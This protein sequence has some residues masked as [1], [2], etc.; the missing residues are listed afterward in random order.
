AAGPL[1]VAVLGRPL[2]LVPTLVVGDLV[3]AD[4]VLGAGH[5]SERE[6]PRGGALGGA[7]GGATE[8]AHGR[9]EGAAGPAGPGS[10]PTAGRR[11]GESLAR[12]L[13][14]ACALS[15]SGRVLAQHVDLGR[16]HAD[17]AHLGAD[18]FTEARRHAYRRGDVRGRLALRIALEG[19]RVRH[20]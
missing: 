16:V 13:G 9:G 12:T 1:V 20:A 3:L 8:R 4:E 15:P 11:G 2:H 18:P 5:E 14:G 7:M 19:D 10:T 17:L 6:E